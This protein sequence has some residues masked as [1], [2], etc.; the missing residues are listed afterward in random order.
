MEKNRKVNETESCFIEKINKDFKSLQSNQVK[1]KQTVN[2]RN[3]SQ[4][5]TTNPN[6][7]KK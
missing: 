5:Y 2:L 6:D 3:E 1:K 7:I 4:I